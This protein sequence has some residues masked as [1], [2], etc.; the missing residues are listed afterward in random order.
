MFPPFQLDLS[1]EQLRRHS[2]TIALRPKTFSVL[3]YLVEHPNMLVTKDALLDAVWAGTVVSDSALKICI[4]ELRHALGDDDKAP[5]FIETVHGRGYRFI[6]PLST[7]QPPEQTATGKSQQ[8]APIPH[9]QHLISTLVGRDSE[10]ALLH[11]YWDKAQRGERQVVFITGEP[12]IG[13]T[14]ILQAFLGQLA[15]ETPVWVAQ[16]QCIEHYGAS[17]AYMP[18]LEALGRLC[19]APEGEQLIDVLSR[20]APTWL[21]QLPALLSADE[22][23]RLQRIVQGATRERMLREMAEAL[24]AV[25]ADRPLILCL[26]DLHWSDISTLDLLSVLARR[27]ERMQLLVLATYRPVEVLRNENPLRAVTQELK[28]HKQCEELRLRLLTANEVETY[29]SERLAGEVIDL[30]TRATLARTIHQRTEGNPLFMV[31]VVED[32]RAQETQGGLSAELR[33]VPATIQQMIERQLDRLRS[34]EQ[35]VLEVASVAGMQFSAA[36]VAAA[37]MMTTSEVEA[38]CAGLVRREQFLR[39]DGISEWPDGTVAAGYR[40]LHALYQD[41]LYERVPAGQRISLHKR[42]G[43]REE[44]AYGDQTRAVA[45]ELA[46]HFTQGREYH[47]AIKYLQQAGENALRRSAH[48]EAI[49]LLAQ[50]LKLIVTLPDTLER[51]RQELT[52]QVA[53]GTSLMATKGQGDPEAGVA[54][55]RA[56]ALCQQLGEESPQFFLVLL[57]LCNFYMSQG[58]LQAA[59]EIGERLLTLAQKTQDPELLAVAHRALGVP[60]GQLGE[61]A[62]ARGHFEHGI[63]L[64]DLR[65]YRSPA[66]RYGGYDPLMA[67]LCWSAWVSWHLGYPDKALQRIHQA[68]TLAEELASPPNL[69]AALSITNMTRQCRRDVQR[70]QEQAEAGITLA[71]EQGTRYWRAIETILRGWALTERGHSEEGLTQIHQGLAAYRNTGS[72]LGQPFFL[73]ILADACCKNGQAEEGL[74]IVAEALAMM[75]RTGDCHYEAEVYRLQGQLTLRQENKE[76]SQESR[77]QEAEACFL[78]ALDVAQTQQ[79][80]S[81][82][83]RAVMSLVRLRQQQAAQNTTG[84]MQ[85]AACSKLADAHQLLLDIYKWFTEGFDT[86][87]LQDAN[88]LL[89]ELV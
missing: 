33:G 84:S 37:A 76:Q 50:G 72:Q 23:E 62:R 11:T 3:R 24:E 32:L 58:K 83:L 10:L 55:G 88:T 7:S 6:A 36:T 27:R 8:A 89:R 74:S 1:N 20:Y 81:L 65:Q 38:L 48:Q 82:E 46:V 41:V 47:K 64:Y 78:K 59:L 4:R 5:R 56:R 69:V 39:T 44:Q 61:F 77:D 51:A 86:K 22:V 40:F 52:F 66:L 18:M 43:E 2:H 49:S 26:E 54:Y 28:F 75:K 68:L 25:T 15:T 67:C 29:I 16:G 17:E 85:H 34:E 9:F 57:G 73:S 19:R 12:G 14:T 13:K 31:T 53:L 71:A 70:V 35:R 87:D 79:A 45:A 60:L 80:K 42:I 21:V 30:K 63:A